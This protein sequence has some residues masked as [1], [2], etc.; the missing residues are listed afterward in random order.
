MAMETDWRAVQE[1]LT[2][3]GVTIAP[4]LTTAEIRRAESVVG[5]EFPDDLRAFLS[6][7]LPT[8]KGFPDWRAPDSKAIRD[9][10]DWPL[11]GIAFDI[12]NDVF[13]WDAWGTRPQDLDEALSSARNHIAAA[14]RLIPVAGHRYI[15]AEPTHEG[16][17]VFSV[18]QTD[19]I[20]YGTDLATYLR[21]E[22]HR[23]SYADAIRQEPR[24]IAFW[25][26]LV[27]A[28]N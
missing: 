22:F 10:L 21:C 16:N 3:A 19:I 5:A 27:R 6:E 4:G 24:S 8:G 26:E 23:L 17:P 12:K 25:S 1:I 14:P 9:Q 15:P 28:N 11:D 20:Y 2:E 18:Y 13:W 7:G